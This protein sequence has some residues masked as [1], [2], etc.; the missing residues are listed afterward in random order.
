[1]LTV[2]PL[3]FAVPEESDFSWLESVC[4]GDGDFSAVFQRGAQTK[5]TAD[6]SDAKQTCRL[7]KEAENTSNSS[8]SRFQSSDS[9]D[10]SDQASTKIFS[11]PEEGCTKSFVRYSALE[12][13]CEYGVHIRSLEKVTLQDRAKLSYAQ[14]LE[15]GQTKELPSV[16][17]SGG[18]DS[19]C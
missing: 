14:H 9:S 7:E 5:I 16:S 11:C 19:P 1:M 3:R 6:V 18:P 8:E 12:R 17:L 15:E 13:H 2:S 4:F 10:S